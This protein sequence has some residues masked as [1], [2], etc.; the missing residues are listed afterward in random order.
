[1]DFCVFSIN[2]LIIM[3]G[4]KA[5]KLKQLTDREFETSDDKSK[6]MVYQ[7]LKSMYK[8]GQ[9]KFTK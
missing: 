4:K 5:R 6:R 3:N 7:D 1:M 9:V 8:K 2:N